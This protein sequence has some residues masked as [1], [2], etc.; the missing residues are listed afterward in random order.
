MKPCAF[1]RFKTLV[2]PFLRGLTVG[3]RWYIHT[4]FCISSQAAA[5][6]PDTL[7]FAAFITVINFQH[8]FAKAH[9]SQ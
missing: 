1:S 5:L 6:I 8:A 3:V 2:S 4:Y 7:E 9:A